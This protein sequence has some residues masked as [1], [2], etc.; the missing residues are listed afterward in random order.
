MIIDGQKKIKVDIKRK[1]E[2]EKTLAIVANNKAID[3][4]IKKNWWLENCNK[5]RNREK[6][7]R[8]FDFK[9]NFYL[10]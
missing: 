5:K 2:K 1:K 9:K 6:K 10:Y 7:L 8:I 3:D 4:K